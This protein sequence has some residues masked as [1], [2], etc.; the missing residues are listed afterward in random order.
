M[1]KYTLLPLLLLVLSCS[2]KYIK[3]NPAGDEITTTERL[4]EFLNN[5]P[6]PKIVLR[7][8]NTGQATEENDVSSL[9][10][11]IEKEFLSQGFI[12]RDRNLFNQVISNNE[13]PWIM[14]S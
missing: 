4:S 14:Q 7:T 13:A 12:V 10:S 8:P 9:Y 3:F 1:K 2:P 5:N 11:A 6:S